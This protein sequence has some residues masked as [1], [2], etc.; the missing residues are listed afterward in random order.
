M[1]RRVPVRDVDDLE[2][3]VGAVDLLERRAEGVDELVRQLVDEAH[4]VGDDGD[5]AVAQLDHVGSSDRVSTNSA[6][7]AR[8]ASCPEQRVEHRALAGVGV[9][10]DRDRRHQSPVAR[11][12]GRLALLADVA[13]RAP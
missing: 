11:P 4:R 2:Q 5:L 7:S 3:H 9:A 13:R 6:F 1:L 12:R 8:A 10:D